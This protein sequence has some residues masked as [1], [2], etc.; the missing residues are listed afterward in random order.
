M[1]GADNA[2]HADEHRPEPTP[3][4][5]LGVIG[6]E[7]RIRPRGKVAMNLAERDCRALSTCS[8]GSRA[9]MPPKQE[10]RSRVVSHRGVQQSSAVGPRQTF[11]ARAGASVQP[12]FLRSS[13]ACPGRFL[14][15]TS[16]SVRL[17]RAAAGRWPGTLS[18][19]RRRRPCF[20]DP[21]AVGHARGRVSLDV[22][23]AGRGLRR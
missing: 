2:A 7:Q 8:A 13:S 21:T 23:A 3:R 20:R 15:I 22:S 19:N 5:S 18:L 17:L 4:P 12:R 16:R 1:A 11:V 14:D 10:S 9:S 6:S